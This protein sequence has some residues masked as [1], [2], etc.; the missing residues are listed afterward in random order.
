[1]HLP[2]KLPV[3]LLT[4]LLGSGKTTL[5]NRLLNHWSDSA[6][7]I[8][9]YGAEPIDRRLV[10]QHCIPITSLGGGCLCCQIR[11]ALVP[12][13]KNLWMEWN[14]QKNFQRLIIEANSTA[15][16]ESVLDVLLRERWLSAR[17]HVQSVVCTLA[18]PTAGEQLNRFPEAWAQSTWADVLVLTQAD[19][20]DADEL[21]HL[22]ARLVTVKK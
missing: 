22:Q 9:E 1:M 8:N 17:L 15:S 21:A 19:L 6:V 3:I 18:V 5:L 13:L 20:A 12:T 14:A 7:L 2:S 10:E 11:G 4:G 16:P